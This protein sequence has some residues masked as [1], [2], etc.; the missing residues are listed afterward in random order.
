MLNSSFVELAH[1]QAARGQTGGC[2]VKV[3][4]LALVAFIEFKPVASV[5]MCLGEAEMTP[6]PEFKPMDNDCV[7]TGAGRQA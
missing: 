1:K 3:D 4:M 6:V 5:F 7:D 2:L